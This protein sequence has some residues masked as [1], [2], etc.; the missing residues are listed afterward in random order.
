MADS[1]PTTELHLRVLGQTADWTL[2]LHGEPPDED[3]LAS[4]MQNG[5]VARLLVAE[6]GSNEPHSLLVNFSL[7]VSVRVV[8]TVRGR[9]VTF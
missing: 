7:V 9:G 8:A 2:L 3:Q 6:Q 1:K 5:T 4:W